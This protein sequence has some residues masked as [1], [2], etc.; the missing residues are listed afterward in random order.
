MV[1]FINGVAGLGRR[2]ID[3]VLGPV[4]GAIDGAK[5]LLGIH[6][7]SRVFRQIGVFTGEG[8]VQG[9]SAMES[10]AQSSMRDLV[11]P[12]E[13]PAIASVAASTASIVP[14]ATG[15]MSAAGG[16]V[17]TA[18]EALIQIA[19]ALSQLQAVGPRDFLMMQRRAERMV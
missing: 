9:L 13:V 6:S 12:P 15:G 4:R 14:A 2:L 11:A 10:A 1:G 16:G 3:A 8:F 5:R 19:E 17:N 18:D 7:P